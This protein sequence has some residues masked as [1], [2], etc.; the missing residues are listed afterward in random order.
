M[1]ASALHWLEHFHVDALRVDAVASMLYRD[2]SRKPGEWIANKYGGRENLES[3]AFLQ[4]LSRVVHQRCPGA[5]LIAEE[6]TAW[7]GVTRSADQG[8]LGFD[9]KWNMGWMHD[10]LH[11]MEDPPIY[12]RWAHDHITFGLVYAF[13]EHFVLPISHDEVVHGKGSL[14]ARMPGD[15]WQRFANLRAY[16]GFMFTH[17][18]KK[19]L[20]MG[21]EFAQ[22]QEWNHDHGLDWFLLDQPRH[23]GVQLLVR[24]LNLLY[25]AIPALHRRDADPA[26][27]AWVVMQDRDQSVFGYLR[28]GDADERP[29]L[30]L[31]NFTP[32]PR[33]NYRV[34]VP[35]EGHW[36]EAMNTDAAAYGGSNV[37]NYGGAWTQAIW[38]H[39]RPFSLNLT[40]PPL[41]TIVLQAD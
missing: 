8:G 3:V 24:D 35:C 19:L 18:G 5:T 32:V 34:G 33:Q 4:D 9:Y 37:G 1:V 26:G 16:L 39:D 22:E 25:R 17:P 15:D 40:L 12:R 30:I 31:C 21:C 10:T 2:Y 28:H 23:A 11:Y 6:S 36:R 20:F 38:Q 14:I 13:S 41:A 29:C 7:P 27:F